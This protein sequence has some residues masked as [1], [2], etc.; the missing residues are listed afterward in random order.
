[1]SSDAASPTQLTAHPVRTAL[2]EL[3]ADGSVTANQAARQLGESSG[4]CSFHLRQLARAGLVEEAPVPPGSGPGRRRPWRL[5]REPTARPAAD[6]EWDPL[7]RELEDEGYR[8]W[9]AGRDQ[10]DPRWRADEA[11]SH[12]LWLT[13]EEM[14]AVAAAVRAV[15]ARFADRERADDR[16]PDARPVALVSRVFPLL[17]PS[18]AG[19]TADPSPRDPLTEREDR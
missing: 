2:L 12:V 7:L 16:P 3:L 9:L 19:D 6:G 11:T 1:M 8:R 17:P 14:T 10:V 5:R 18:D 13:P 4:S 15:A